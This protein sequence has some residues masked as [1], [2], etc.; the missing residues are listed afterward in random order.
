MGSAFL[1]DGFTLQLLD[2]NRL[3]HSE[4]GSRGQNISPDWCKRGLTDGK[5]ETTEKK[6]KGQ[7][8]ME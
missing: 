5:M 8:E 7:I 3:E 6:R 4:Q 1:V 2:I